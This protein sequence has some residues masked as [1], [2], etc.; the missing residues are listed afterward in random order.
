MRQELLASYYPFLLV[1][2]L[3]F[4]LFK[5]ATSV[6]HTKTRYAFKMM[7]FVWTCWGEVPLRNQVERSVQRKAWDAKGRELVSECGRQRGG[8]WGQG[9]SMPP[10]VPAQGVQGVGEGYLGDS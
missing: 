2:G 1:Q 9:D 6:K 8:N 4:N 7:S 5:K 10:S 3:D